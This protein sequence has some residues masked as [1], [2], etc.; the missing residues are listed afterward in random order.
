MP[1]I[2]VVKYDGN[3]NVFAWK[4]PDVELGAKT[5][6]IVNASQEAIFVKGGEIL[7]RFGPGRHTLNT[8]NL[9]I[10]RRV[11]NLPFGGKSPFTAEIWFIN[12][13]FNLDIKWGTPSPIQLQDPKYGIVVPVRANGVFGINID[14]PDLFFT[15]LVGTLKEFDAVAISNYFRGLYVTNVKDF[16]SNFIINKKISVL[17][18]N[19]SLAE[20]SEYM[21]NRVSPIMT[22]YGIQLASFYINEISFPDEDAS[23]K[24]L[25]EAL[26]KKAEMNIVGYDYKQERTFNTLENMIKT[27]NYD[28]TDTV[29]EGLG[30]I[31][32]TDSQKPHLCPKCNSA[33]A[34]GQ[35]F[36]G[37]C[38]F[39]TAATLDKDSGICP[40]CGEK[41]KK[42]MK[43]CPE[44]GQKLKTVCPTCGA[45]YGKPLKF[46]PECGTKLV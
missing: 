16:I 9:P 38:G 35:R 14:E 29:K 44:C 28:D 7:D 40:N 43:F 11:V 37:S 10:L 34:A 12:K 19:A 32:T 15:K 39:D 6:L 8:E 18:I 31:N 45:E 42:G 24:K 21:N 2:K 17:E 13:A 3:P 23:I 36:C 1:L 26:A 25:K 46:C 20:L 4:F 30:F 22:E 5:Q 33:M 27:G 41:Y